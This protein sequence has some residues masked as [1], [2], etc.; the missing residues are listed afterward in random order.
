MRSPHETF[1]FYAGDTW[2]M[3]FACHNVDGTPMVLDNTADILWKLDDRLKE[4]RLLTLTRSSGVIIV[5][6]DE[7]ICLVTVTPEQSAMLGPGRYF[8]ELSV[9][10]AG[11]FTMSEGMVLVKRRLP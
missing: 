7:G 3:L 11:Q 9:T 1:E 6:V 5:S 2:P 4:T 10:K 8:D